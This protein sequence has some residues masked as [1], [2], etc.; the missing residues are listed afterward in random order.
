VPLKGFLVKV[1]RKSEYLWIAIEVLEVPF[2]DLVVS[3][4]FSSTKVLKFRK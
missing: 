2:T 1:I 4:K 3:E